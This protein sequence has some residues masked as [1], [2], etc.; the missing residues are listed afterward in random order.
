M[1]CKQC[2]SR[3]FWAGL[4]LAAVIIAAFFLARHIRSNNPNDGIDKETNVARIELD[5][6]EYDKQ[7]AVF[8]LK[9]YA[10]DK[11]EVKVVS[12]GWEGLHLF[13]HRLDTSDVWT[14]ITL[15]IR[16]PSSSGFLLNT[17]D[18]LYLEQ[19]SFPFSFTEK[20][21]E[22]IYN[23]T[24][25]TLVFPFVK[26]TKMTKIEENNFHL[27]VLFFDIFSL[28]F[29]DFSFKEENL[30]AE[31]AIEAKMSKLYKDVYG[32]DYSITGKINISDYPYVRLIIGGK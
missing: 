18:S 4:A 7:K 19:D 2:T 28:Q 17:E 29:D 11:P 5:A 10:F 30:S 26:L 31:I 16:L 3:F 9:H 20:Y 8:Q 25:S 1:A 13:F 12:G 27:D 6:T 21:A 24:D 22:D 14:K 32:G 15:E 23:K